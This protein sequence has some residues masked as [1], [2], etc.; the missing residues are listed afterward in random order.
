ML[1][2]CQIKIDFSSAHTLLLNV[3]N[4]RLNIHIYIKFTGSLLIFFFQFSR[5]LSMHYLH[6][7][8][9]Q[10]LLWLFRDYFHSVTFSRATMLRF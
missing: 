9:L 8:F 10:F 5:E 3:A 4:Q 6:H 7:R 1:D 2:S